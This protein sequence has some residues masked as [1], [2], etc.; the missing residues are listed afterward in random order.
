MG[1]I[2]PPPLLKVTAWQLAIVLALAGVTG[3]FDRVWACSVLVGGLIQI[4]GGAYFSW[5][6]FRYRGARQIQ[7]TVQSMYR[8]ETG[9]ILLSAALFVLAFLTIESLSY[10]VLFAA[11]ILMV[12]VHAGLVAKMYRVRGH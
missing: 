6:A 3:I 2:A 4:I 8:G 7:M 10:T 1:T 11:Y 12:G 9:K 5:L